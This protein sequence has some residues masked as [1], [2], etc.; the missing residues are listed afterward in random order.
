M[1]G[2]EM[3]T[4]TDRYPASETHLRNEQR[5]AV[6]RYVADAAA[7]H[8]KVSTKLAAKHRA[9]KLAGSTERV[10]AT[11][12]LTRATKE[13]ALLMSILGVHPLDQDR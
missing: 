8:H 1:A 3:Q 9:A 5:A 6:A 4:L 11:R 10:N 12:A 2:P 7:R 13:A